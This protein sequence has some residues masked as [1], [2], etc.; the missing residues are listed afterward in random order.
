MIQPCEFIQLSTYAI[1]SPPFLGKR[2]VP[3]NSGKLGCELGLKFSET[4][5]DLLVYLASD[6]RCA[7][8]PS[9][10]E[11]ANRGIDIICGAKNP[12]ASQR[13]VRSAGTAKEE[14]DEDD[15][16]E[17]ICSLRGVVLALYWVVLLSSIY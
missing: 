6:T 11:E 3:R 14:E 17:T 15:I 8:K 7:E 9:V 16:P 13:V 5:G 4:T 1:S 10:A 2:Q 12:V